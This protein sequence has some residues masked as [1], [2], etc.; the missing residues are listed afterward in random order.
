MSLESESTIISDIAA[1]AAALLVNR[2]RRPLIA[3][4]SAVAEPEA[5]SSLTEPHEVVHRHPGGR[6]RG[7]DGVHLPAGDGHDEDEEDGG[8]EAE[9]DGAREARGDAVGARQRGLL[10]AEPDEGGELEE[11]P[12]AVEEVGGGHD[13]VE[14]EEGHG[15]RDGGGGQDADPRRAEDRGAGREEAREQ[16]QVRH[17]QQL[18]RRAAQRRRVEAD[19]GQHRAHLDPVLEP[20]AGDHACVGNVAA[21]E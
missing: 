8:D 17:P 14:A 13:A 7:A 21:G 3:G 12:E 1:V 6:E 15:Q 9:Q 18:E 11:H 5:P 19:G 20:V 4:A 2:R 10:D 16:A